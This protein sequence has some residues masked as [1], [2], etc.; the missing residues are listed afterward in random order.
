MTYRVLV[1]GSRDWVD[2]AILRV[3]ND[4]LA[5]ANRTGRL[6]TVVHGGCPTGADA[7]ADVWARTLEITRRVHMAEWR[8]A[9]IYNPQAG[10]ARNE[11]MV[12]EG[13]DLCLAFIRN[14]S[15]GATHCADLARR[16]G[17]PIVRFTA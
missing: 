12:A 10:L 16:A 15:R 7:F 1:T 2:H 5:D 6:M 17:I 13:A 4:T 14:G 8:P 3:L 9:G 11:R